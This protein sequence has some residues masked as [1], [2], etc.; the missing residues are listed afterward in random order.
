MLLVAVVSARFLGPIGYG[1]LGIVQS[2]ISMLSSFVGFGIGTTATKYVAHHMRSQPERAGGISSLLIVLTLAAGVVMMAAMYFLAPWI[3]ARLLHHPGIEPLLTGGALLLT[4]SLL[5][6]VLS[7][8][9]AGFEAFRA[10]ARINMWQSLIALLVTIPLVVAYRTEGAIAALT[11]NT[12]IGIILF[13][14]ALQ[15]Q[16]RKN[17]MLCILDRSVLEEWP[18][19]LKFTAPAAA[20]GAIVA[21]TVWLMNT[22]LAGQAGGYGQLGIFQAAN[23]WRMAVLALFTAAT[24]GVLPVLSDAQGRA[25]HAG[26]RDGIRLTLRTTGILFLPLVVAAIS[27][28]R[29]L[30]W[31]FGPQFAEAAPLVGILMAAVFLEVMNGAIGVALAGSGRIVAGMVMNACWALVMIIAGNA[32]VPR[33]G[34]QGL[35]VTYLVAFALHA[36]WQVIFFE[37]NIVR[38]AILGEWRLLFYA[39]VLITAAAWIGESKGG[40]IPVKMMFVILSFLPLISFLRRTMRT[41]YEGSKQSD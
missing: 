24:A 38:W 18:I 16:Q 30:A 25:D 36:I 2:T 27:A 26:F 37:V 4:T 13:A 41:A 23:Q 11:I 20:S 12:A 35:A 19:L 6:G 1:E 40:R 5:A 15:D 39:I 33:Y 9:L 32:L 28:G 10:I 14:I 21:P 22:L 34:A 29:E 3:A 7:S 8:L 17:G 31:I